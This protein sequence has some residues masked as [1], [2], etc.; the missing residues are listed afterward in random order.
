MKNIKWFVLFSVVITSNCSVH[1][2]L[3]NKDY[4]DTGIFNRIYQENNNAFY[5]S[6]TKDHSTIWT[7]N[8]SKIDIYKL[9][10]SKII[11]KYSSSFQDY[12]WIADYKKGQKYD[13]DKCAELD[14]SIIGFKIKIGNQL[15]VENLALNIDC[16]VSNEY[17]SN[18]INQLSIAIKQLKLSKF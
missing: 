3:L 9:K 10:N 11:Q 17:S 12:S 18:F 5:I 16:F 8:K 6:H 2:K 14:G 13:V 1:N 7:Y 15:V 4:T